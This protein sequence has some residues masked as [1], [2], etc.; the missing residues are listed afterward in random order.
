[1]AGS[2]PKYNSGCCLTHHTAAT[3]PI[4]NNI[5]ISVFLFYIG[6]WSYLASAISSSPR[7]YVNVELADDEQRASFLSVAGYIRYTAV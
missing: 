3:S 7:K 4:V 6:R 5:E 2:F 1:M